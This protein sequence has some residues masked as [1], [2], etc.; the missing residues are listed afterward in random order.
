MSFKKFLLSAV[1]L[2][3]LFLSI[4]I[5]A[6][7]IFLTMWGLKIYTDH[8]QA[9]PVSNFI[10]L[11]IPEV[12]EI[13][14]SHNLR[15]KVI[16]SAYVDNVAPGSVIDQLPKPGFRVKDNRTILLTINAS[17]P[18]QVMLP[19]LRGISFRQAKVLL[20]NCGLAI[21]KISHQPSEYNDLVLNVLIDSTEVYMGESYAKGTPIDIVV[22]KTSFLKKTAV[23]DVLGMPVSL[24]KST[25]NEIM[26][27][28]GVV[29]YD[30]TVLTKEDTLNAR[31]WKQRPDPRITPETEPGSSI[32]MWATVDELKINDA[33]KSPY[34]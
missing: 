10:G 16:D 24:A 5:L 33:I 29:I 19:K 22:G 25:L 26:L 23:P 3:N 8:G 7:L 9:R 13:V 2:K 1:F 20:E 32:D 28:T 14:A 30:E 31:I 17:S 6:A 34:K 12:E 11:S 27:N 4:V 15:F 21:G 18:E